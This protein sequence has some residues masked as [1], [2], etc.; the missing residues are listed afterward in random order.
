M[1]YYSE[2][3]KNTWVETDTTA[4]N[5][6]IDLAIKSQIITMHEFT[7]TICP[8][9]PYMCDS[10]KF[11][12]DNYLKSRYYNEGQTYKDI[13]G[14]LIKAF[15]NGITVDTFNFFRTKIC[16]ACG[17]GC[18]QVY[19]GTSCTEKYLDQLKNRTPL[20]CSKRTTYL[21]QKKT[22]FP[23]VSFGGDKMLEIIN[24][25]WKTNNEINNKERTYCPED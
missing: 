8:I 5:S 19:L 23:L 6:A 13:M 16:K 17:E 18:K 15:Y 7:Y 14:V 1:T 12:W 21:T 3:C 2:Q 25:L 11:C 10:S 9:C 20:G 22:V 4:I 24:K